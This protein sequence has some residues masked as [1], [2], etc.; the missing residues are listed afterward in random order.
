[1]ESFRC[2]FIV[3][4]LAVLFLCIFGSQGNA[5]ARTNNLVKS[6]CELPLL[7]QAV[8]DNALENA[9]FKVKVA[10]VNMP[11]GEMNAYLDAAERHLAEDIRQTYNAAVP[12]AVKRLNQIHPS[13]ALVYYAVKG[14]TCVW[15]VDGNGVL[16]SGLA[17][18][19]N[20]NYVAALRSN[21]GVT[22]H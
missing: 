22:C 10:A 13:V 8:A 3:S 16:A 21:M 12:A 17:P 7:T 18:V 2:N 14:G 6:R 19:V 5:D 15:L 20:G 9:F 11:S 1:M 4:G